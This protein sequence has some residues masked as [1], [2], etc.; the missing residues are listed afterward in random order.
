MLGAATSLTL[1]SLRPG[2][3]QFWFEV[4][5]AMA[6]AQVVAPSYVTRAGVAAAVYDM[7][8]A[9]YIHPFGRGPNPLKFPGQSE[10]HHSQW[11]DPGGAYT[12][13]KNSVPCAAHARASAP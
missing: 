6:F 1:T 7:W 11:V 10:Q 12:Q 3:M 13:S 8:H 9:N 4:A 2:T 5:R